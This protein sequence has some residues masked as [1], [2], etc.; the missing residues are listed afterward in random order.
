MHYPPEE[1]SESAELGGGES[2]EGIDEMDLAWYRSACHE[3]PAG[4]GQLQLAPT[5]VIR[6]RAPRN[7]TLLDQPVNHDR[8]RALVSVGALGQ[9]IDGAG[10][11]ASELLE[12]E[13]LGASNSEFT[14]G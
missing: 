13:E 2:P 3:A 12:H 14:L 9:L 11:S 1:A 4:F 6:R 10:R 7:K 5:P 8:N